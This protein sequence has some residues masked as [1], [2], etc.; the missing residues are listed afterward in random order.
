MSYLTDL[1]R[2]IQT[3]I[4]QPVGADLGLPSGGAYSSYFPSYEVTSP[5]YITPSAYSLAQAGYRTNEV[6]YAIIAK[7]AK[8]KAEAPLWVY[9][10]NGETPEEIKDHGIRKLLKRVNYGVGEKMFWQISQIYKDIAGFAAW[11]IESN[12]FGEPI[13]LWPMRP[14]WCSFLRGPDLSGQQRPLR[15]IRYQPYGLPPQDIP[16]ERIVFDGYFDPLYPLIKFY[17]PT[18]N[19]LHQI[20]LDNSM[21]E[22]LNDFTRHGAKFAGMISVAQVLNQNQADDIKRRFREAHGGTQNWTDPLVLGLGSK[23]ETMQ[24]SFKDMEFPELDAR[25]ESRI[26]MSFEISPIIINAKV[27]L[28]RS[29]YSNYEQANK[30]WYNEWVSPEWQLT[31]DVF[32]EQMLPKY[33]DDIQ[34]YYCE[35]NT[36]KVKALQ[37]DRTA[38]VT[39]A[40][41]MYG[42][43]VAQLD[44]SREEIGL[45]PVGGPE[46]KAFYEVV[47]VAANQTVNAEGQVGNTITTPVTDIQPQTYNE[48]QKAAKSQAEI[49]AETAETKMYRQFAKRRIKENKTADIPEYE[50]KHLDPEKQKELIEQYTTIAM[51]VSI[52]KTLQG[53]K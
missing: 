26:C 37:E 4:N 33:H 39:R 10:D 18:M 30:A 11:E 21:T 20:G 19:A 29:T 40:V 24:M 27:G 25:T 51:A 3:Q 12:N 45:D 16:I 2:Q 48:K 47:R 38:K 53:V 7:R 49:D 43:R 42:G 50:F 23:Y 36:G 44:E 15:A 22:F 46:G 31:A 8:A 14:D 28:E 1:Q 35:F 5:Q 9:D 34:N 32:G 41:S 17:S 13:R 6:I 52:E